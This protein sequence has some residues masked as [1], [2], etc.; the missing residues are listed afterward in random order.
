MVSYNLIGHPLRH[1]FTRFNARSG[2]CAIADGWSVSTFPFISQSVFIFVVWIA[3]SLS[4]LATMMWAIVTLFLVST[5]TCRCG[6]NT[7][8]AYS[9]N[10]ITLI[11][12]H[13]NLSTVRPSSRWIDGSQCK[14]FLLCTFYCLQAFR[15]VLGTI[16]HPRPMPS[17]LLYR[18]GTP[19]LCPW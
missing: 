12:S 1:I 16:K 5:A 18:C 6:S 13:W 9:D 10:V 7:S 2:G 3:F 14:P 11:H 17:W 15:E 8:K 4:V 19:E